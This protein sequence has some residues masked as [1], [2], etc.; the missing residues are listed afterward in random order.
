MIHS[1]ML[2][3]VIAL[4]HCI[5]AVVLQGVFF[6]VEFT[7]TTC[8]A[9]NQW[10]MWFDTADPNIIQGEFEVTKHIQ[11]IFSGFMCPMPI[12]IEVRCQ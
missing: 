7:E 8:S 11:Q 12:A 3:I 1:Q 10:T 6:P 4:L 2:C 5:T 9:G